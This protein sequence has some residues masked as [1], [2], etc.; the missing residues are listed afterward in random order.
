MCFTSCLNQ[1]G[2]VEQLFFALQR[3]TPEQWHSTGHSLDLFPRA[4][5]PVQKSCEEQ[6]EKHSTCGLYNRDFHVQE[7][8]TL[9]IVY[10]ALLKGCRFGG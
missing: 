5:K 1:A 2:P 8:K 6:G 4:A 3:L 7:Q 10:I 9:K